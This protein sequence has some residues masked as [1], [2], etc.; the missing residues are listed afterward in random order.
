MSL[1]AGRRNK[2]IVI[3]RE[4]EIG[5]DA[6]NNPVRDWTQLANPWADVI[7]GS[8]TERRS[9]AQTG[10]TQAATF[11]VLKDSRTATLLMTDRILFMG[12]PWDIRG[13]A[14][15]GNEGVRIDA[16]RQVP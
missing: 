3:Q 1:D 16:V 5:R 6:L 2:R 8:G 7:F 4:T 15:I 11:E 14:P 12:A 10:G 13:I 9:A